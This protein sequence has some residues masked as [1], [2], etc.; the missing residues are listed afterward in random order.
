MSRQNE[1][2]VMPIRIYGDKC[3][4]RVS[5]E[6]IDIN[7]EIRSVVADLIET[8]YA[9]DGV[10]LAAPQIGKN[11]RIFVVDPQWFQTNERNPFVFINPKIIFMNGVDTS[12]EGCLSLPDVV[13]DVA[14]SK[15]IIIEAK[16]EAGKLVQHRAEGLFARAVQH[17]FD[18]LDGILFVDRVSKLKFFSLKSKLKRLEKLCD[19]DGINTDIS[20]YNDDQ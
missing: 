12:E 9:K 19:A 6:V 10:G 17:E 5:S 20:I 14:R 11:V 18:H 8:M 15:E 13:S 3:L 2:K 4:R 16:N 7:D 1:G